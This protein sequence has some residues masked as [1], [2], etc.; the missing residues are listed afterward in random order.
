MWINIHDRCSK[1]V[2]TLRFNWIQHPE[3]ILNEKLQTVCLNSDYL[4]NYPELFEVFWRKLYR[5]LNK[6]YHGL[7]DLKTPAHFVWKIKI[8]WKKLKCRQRN[9]QTY[10]QIR[11]IITIAQPRKRPILEK[12]RE[13]LVVDTR[14]EQLKENDFVYKSFRNLTSLEQ[15]NKTLKTLGVLRRTRFTW[16]KSPIKV[17]REKLLV[18][19]LQFRGFWRRPYF[20]Q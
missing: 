17:L 6:R 5:R 15:E 9:K 18:A 19:G 20:V 1:A 8:M 16:K 4:K 10:E 13:K 3:V 11:K 12:V 14:F 7:L 2:R